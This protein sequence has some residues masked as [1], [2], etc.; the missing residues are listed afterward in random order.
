MSNCSLN[1]TAEVQIFQLVISIP[2]FILGLVGNVAVLAILCCRRGKTWS[3]MMVYIANMAFADCSALISLPFRMYSYQNPWPF[4]HDFCLLLV[5]TYYVN[6]YVSIF[7]ATAIS[8]VR[9]VAIKYPFK[10]KVIMSPRK[11]LAVCVLIWVTVCS[12]SATFHFVD[13]PKNDTQLKCFQKNRS[14]PLPLSFILALDVVGFLLPLITMAFCSLKVIHTLS[15]QNKV[16]SRTEKIQCSRIIAANLIVFLICFSPF[17]IGFLLKFLVE[18]HWPEDCNL[19]ESIHNF[20][21]VSFCIASTNC[22][23][24]AF[25][26][27]FATRESWRKISKCCNTEVK[28]PSVAHTSERLMN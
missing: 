1:I 7:T 12:F 2:T 10:A 26:Y 25:S 6:M 11:A 15:K 17:H 22:C 21:H 16:S 8:V 9:Y 18:T 24:D 23:L 28:S 27:Y 3:Y 20:V 5:S 19:L 4:P 14:K 13:A